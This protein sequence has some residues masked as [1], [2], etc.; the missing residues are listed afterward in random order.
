MNKR[1]ILSIGMC[2]VLALGI[3]TSALAAEYPDRVE[4]EVYAR[5]ES[6]FG[7]LTARYMT[8]EEIKESKERDEKDWEEETPVK[9]K[10]KVSDDLLKRLSEQDR[11]D[12]EGVLP[13]G[14][15][16]KVHH[17]TPEEIEAIENGES[18]ALSYHWTG[19]VHVPKSNVS[20]T[21]GTQ[22]GYDF[23]VA[24]H[25]EADFIIK[26][27]PTAMPTINVG[28]S[29]TNGM[30]SDWIPNLK[31]YTTVTLLPEDGAEYYSYNFKVSTSESNTGIG[32]FEI[33]TR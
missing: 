3:S 28:V 6:K 29:A 23:V 4:G 18:E 5:R 22:V 2:S 11:E 31:E 1:K 12:Y 16:Y 8:A 30:W 17:M 32:R 21:N 19:N 13:N 26:N 15:E 14:L 25:S 7:S 24:P 9:E 27:L 10:Y 20:G 33:R